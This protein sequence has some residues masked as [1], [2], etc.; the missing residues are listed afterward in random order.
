[1]NLCIERT[2]YLSP[3]TWATTTDLLSRMTERSAWKRWSW[4][5]RPNMT[6]RSN[7]TRCWYQTVSE[8]WRTPSKQ[9]RWEIIHLLELEVVSFFSFTKFLPGFVRFVFAWFLLKTA[10]SNVLFVLCCAKPRWLKKRLICNNINYRKRNVTKPL[11]RPALFNTLRRLCKRTLKSA[12]R[13]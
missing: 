4:W 8:L 10:L 7:V 11:A 9:Y 5:R 3:G 6:M 13:N 1:M 12:Q 2:G